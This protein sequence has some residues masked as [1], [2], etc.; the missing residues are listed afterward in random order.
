MQPWR[1]RSG[2]GLLRVLGSRLSHKKKIMRWDDLHAAAYTC[3]VVEC[4]LA[5]HRTGV[6]NT[7]YSSC[8]FFQQGQSKCAWSTKCMQ[9]MRVT[10]T[11][12][13]HTYMLHSQERMQ[14]FLESTHCGVRLQ[15]LTALLGQLSPMPLF[16]LRNLV[17]TYVLD[18]FF[19]LKLPVGF[20]IVLDS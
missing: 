10:L 17:Q 20:L 8:Y 14:L 2:E 7:I 19:F 6:A 4:P 12:V 3:V 15:F 18:S 9:I 11:P 13:L 16:L 1:E 5:K